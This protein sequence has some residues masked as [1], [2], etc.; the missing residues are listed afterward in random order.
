MTLL[1]RRRLLA[2]GAFVVAAGAGTAAAAATRGTH[3]SPS[4]PA[5]SS[6]LP[7]PS[8]PPAA[9]TNT[10]ARERELIAT[11]DTA[12]ALDSPA[13][14]LLANIRD[15]HRAHADALVAAIGQP[16]T[17]ATSSTS[18]APSSGASTAQSSTAAS[19]VGTAP[20]APLR[21]AEGVAQQAAVSASASLTGA[22]AVLLASIGA[23]EAGHVAL[24]AESS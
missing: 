15:D 14:A 12:L 19:D 5:T 11:L 10:L 24:L 7:P 4:R 20:T 13:A 2:L 16:A 3:Q 23:C 17:T 8:P 1:S 21:A 22:N 18:S 6:T 9:L